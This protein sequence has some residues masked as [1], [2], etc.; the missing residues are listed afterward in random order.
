MHKK[1]DDWN[2][3]KKYIHGDGM[4]KFYHDREV[5]WC[6][7]GVNIGFEQ[8][9]TNKDAERPVLILK[10]FSK[11]VCL[12]VPLTTSVKKN[13]Y[14]IALGKVGDKNAFAIV[15]Q[16]RLVD[17]KRLVNKIGFID[18]DLFQKIRKVIKDLL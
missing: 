8:D 11:D 2:E 9:G 3:S 13:P 4:S 17:T 7:L 5:W 1:F 18:K 15:S 10:G 14:H 6:S 12:I 16:I